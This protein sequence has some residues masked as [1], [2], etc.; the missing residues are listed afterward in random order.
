MPS[1]PLYWSSGSIKTARAASG[2]GDVTRYTSQQCFSVYACLLCACTFGLPSCR[3]WVKGATWASTFPR[4]NRRPMLPRNQFSIILITWA[5]LRVNIDFTQEGG[6]SHETV[7]AQPHVLPL[8]AIVHV[9][10]AWL[11]IK[12]NTQP[13]DGLIMVLSHCDPTGRWPSR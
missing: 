10:V 13:C 11:Y 7:S 1:A 6:F 12:P 5:P 9:T 8:D 2:N 3:C 4:L